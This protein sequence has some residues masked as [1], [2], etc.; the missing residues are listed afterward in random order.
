MKQKLLPTLFFTLAAALSLMCYI[1]VNFHAIQPT[2]TV[3][4]VLALEQSERVDDE[5][6][7]D[8]TTRPNPGVIL[9]VFRLIE[10]FVPQGN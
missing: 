10:K 1:Y 7:E 4:P 6:N 9:Q 8:E 2:S 3:K 5:S